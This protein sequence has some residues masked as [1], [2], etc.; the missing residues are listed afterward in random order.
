[1]RRQNFLSANSE[2]PSN[3]ARSSLDSTG[4]S[5][6]E[7]DGIAAIPSISCWKANCGGSRERDLDAKQTY[8]ETRFVPR[9]CWLTKHQPKPRSGPATPVISNKSLLL[10]NLESLRCTVNADR[11]MLEN[12]LALYMGS[13]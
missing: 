6:D 3:S 2:S 13:G 9:I 11:A 12:Y 10:I 7:N 1:M 8:T 5:V 4:G